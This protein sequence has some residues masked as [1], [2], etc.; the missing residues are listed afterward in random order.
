MCGIRASSFNSRRG[1]TG[2]E[3]VNCN[4]YFF[5]KNDQTVG[6]YKETEPLTSKLR[7]L[8]ALVAD[9]YESHPSV[10]NSYSVL[11]EASYLNWILSYTR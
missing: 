1:F 7:Q 5:Y 2:L 11:G 10:P 9:F 6:V 4:I 3:N 8:A